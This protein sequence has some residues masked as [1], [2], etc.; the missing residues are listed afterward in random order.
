M[1]GI[2]LYNDFDSLQSAAY[3][4]IWSPGAKGNLSKAVKFVLWS[5]AGRG[6]FNMEENITCKCLSFC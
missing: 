2:Y 6:D 1:V 3:T 4:V 5:L